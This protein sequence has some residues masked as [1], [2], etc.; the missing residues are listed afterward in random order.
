MTPAPDE[1]LPEDVRTARLHMVLSTLAIGMMGLALYLAYE[2][3]RTPVGPVGR[4]CNLD[5]ESEVCEE[6]ES[7]VDGLCQLTETR[8][9][10]LPCQ[11]GDPCGSCVCDGAFA[12]DPASNRCTPRQEDTCSAALLRSLADVRR[13][14]REQCTSKGKGAATCP[15]KD[16]DSFFVKHR[17]FDRLLTELQHAATVHFDK[18][19]PGADGLRPD[20][21]AYYEK[22][23]GSM[24]QRLRDARHI[25]VIGRASDD[26]PRNRAINYT[27]AQLR[28]IEVQRWITELGRTPQESDEME[29]K[30]ITLAIGTSHPLD[31]RLL[32]ERV[33]HHFI[34]WSPQSTDKLRT[35]VRTHATLDSETSRALRRRLD[36]SVLVVPIPCEIPDDRASREPKP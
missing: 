3:T 36:Q 5:T 25:L 10:P 8:L 23:L 29:R 7:C 31:P 26:N 35:W 27:L 24:R 2:L 14:E 17:D 13:F 18:G 4:G 28:M 19:Q 21:Q 34:A 30:L 11:E 22:E 20:H 9:A 16:L 32:M 6:D 12:C 15:A 33:Y 1:L